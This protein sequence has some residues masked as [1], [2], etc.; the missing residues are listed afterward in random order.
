MLVERVG[1]CFGPE[2]DRVGVTKHAS[3]RFASGFSTSFTNWTTKTR[4]AHAACVAML[5]L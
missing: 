3:N 2:T 1:S 4:H 5:G